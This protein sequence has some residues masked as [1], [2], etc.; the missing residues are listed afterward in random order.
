MHAGHDICAAKLVGIPP[1]K[2]RTSDPGGPLLW[3]A[4]LLPS[5]VASG[6]D[7]VHENGLSLSDT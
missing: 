5:H 7:P 2:L 6:K 1:C 4:G 3:K